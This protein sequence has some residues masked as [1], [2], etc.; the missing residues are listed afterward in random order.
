MDGNIWKSIFIGLALITL[1]YP[2][3][4]VFGVSKVSLT[5]L[6]Y[7]I[8]V[9]SLFGYVFTVQRIPRRNAVVRLKSGRVVEGKINGDLKDFISIDNK[10]IKKDEI[11]S[12]EYLSSPTGTTG[13]SEGTN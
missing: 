2:V 6:F 1:S 5:I 9:A 4:F 11:I 7:I 3:V 8:P 10:L 12:I 13:R